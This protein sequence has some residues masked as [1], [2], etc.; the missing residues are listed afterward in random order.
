MTVW[1]ADQA[2]LAALGASRALGWLDRSFLLILP[3]ANVIADRAIGYVGNWNGIHAGHVRSA[4]L[5]AFLAGW[6][7]RLRVTDVNRASLV[8]LAYVSLLVPLASDLGETLTQYHKV[9]VSVLLFSV[10]YQRIRGWRDLRQLVL[11][12][13]AAVVVVVAHFLAVQVL[14]IGPTP[15]L[16]GLA[17]YWGPREGREVYQAYVLAYGVLIYPLLV[18]L[19]PVARPMLRTGRVVLLGASVLI[20]LL[21]FR[22]SAI[23]ATLAG[24]AV[25][26]ARTR[27]IRLYANVSLWGAIALLATWP[28]FGP[29]LLTLL[30]ARAD[31]VAFVQA[32]ESGRMA[33]FAV[34]LDEFVRGSPWH[35]LF[36]SDLFNS[37]AFLGVTRPIHVDYLQLLLGSGAV[38]LMM[39]LGMYAALA[40]AARRRVRWGLHIPATREAA[41][42]FLGLIVGSMTLSLGQQILVLTPFSL[43]MT[44]LGGILGALTGERIDGGPPGTR[45]SGRASGVG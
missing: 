8:F 38:G 4:L 6:V 33:E 16:E 43:G 1:L 35:R 3:A 2:A 9:L 13:Y 26:L 37:R 30:E 15:Y 21:M 25:Y 32:T 44:L 22:R 7:P 41:G 17:V 19:S 40:R 34:V 29:T 24:G 42:V 11:G 28:V 12:V 5:L 18:V 20:L 27:H 39:F 31:I 23:L 14:R 45:A 10:A 36:G